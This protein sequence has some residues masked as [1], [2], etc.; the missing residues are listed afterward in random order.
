MVSAPWSCLPCGISSEGSNRSTVLQRP[1]H[2]FISLSISGA[3][4]EVS[5]PVWAGAV[6]GGVLVAAPVWSE[7]ACAAAKVAASNEM[8]SEASVFM[9]E[10]RDRGFARRTEKRQ[11]HDFGGDGL[12]FGFD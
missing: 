11:R 3:G 5:L 6:A 1:S 10:H 9:S 2:I 4:L 12:A 7:L 8:N